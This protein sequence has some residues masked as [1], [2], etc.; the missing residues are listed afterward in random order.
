[1]P[2]KYAQPRPPLPLAKVNPAIKA[3]D[4]AKP[5]PV[6]FQEI[7]RD[8][9]STIVARIKVQTPNGHAFI[10]RR[11]D[12]GAIS[13]TTMFRAA[14]PTA[15]D[16]EEKAE[17]SWVKQTY[18]TSGSNKSG[19]ARFA[20]TWV[21]T[22]IALSI[23]ESYF[24]TPL[25]VP[26][27]EAEPDPNAIHR[28]SS[29]AQNAQQPTPAA[30][31][32]AAPLPPLEAPAAKRRRESSPVPADVNSPT[33]PPK[34]NSNATPSKPPSTKATSPL[35]TRSEKPPST[36]RTPLKRFTPSKPAAAPAAA[37]SPPP[38][39][40]TRRSERLRSP[41]PSAKA[42]P[43]FSTFGGS[44]K[45]PKSV[46]K[47][48]REEIEVSTPA[49]SDET[50]VEEEHHVLK[51]AEPNMAEDIREQKEL[52][53]KLVAEREAKKQQQQQDAIEI[54]DD[55]DTTS[56]G[57]SLASKR[58]REES[59]EKPQ[60]T[61]NIKEH[62]Q[63]PEQRVIASNSRV[64]LLGNMPPERKSLAWG[65]LAFAAGLGAV[66]FLPNLTNFF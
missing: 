26:L 40:P 41:P 64:R 12:T 18:D 23:A 58:A 4:P 11:L 13:L 17:L 28:K 43:S 19:K 15:D 3:I 29:K 56:I 55:E 49:G 36:S 24:L 5:P 57:A 1:M 51:V 59:P 16:E 7:V 38:A 35:P 22:D 46:L 21:S 62:D 14:F 20:G 27:A 44:P 50:V 32:I 63:E 31:P 48:V 2:S 53:A 34:P 9:S 25:I 66:S 39:T 10:L 6:K 33:P 8:G 37:M 52:I 30:S 54:D 61:L 42:T 45:T 65:A 47:V 60:Y